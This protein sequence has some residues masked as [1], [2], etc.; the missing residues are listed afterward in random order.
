MRM[1]RTNARRFVF[2][3]KKCVAL[4]S[5]GRCES[6]SAANLSYYFHVCV[7]LQNNDWEAARSNDIDCRCSR[8]FSFGF[9]GIAVLCV[10][11]YAVRLCQ[12]VDWTREIFLLFF[13]AHIH[14]SKWW[15]PLSLFLS[16]NRHIPSSC[17]R[18]RDLSFWYHFFLTTLCSTGHMIGC[19]DGGCLYQWTHE[20]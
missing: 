1:R 10:W 4:P 16:L 3:E 5:K 20:K 18:R 8:F 6:G 13:Y 7:C 2:R 11:V 12:L 14:S 17:E 15:V 19:H 9:N